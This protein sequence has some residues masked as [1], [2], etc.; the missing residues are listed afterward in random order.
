MIEIRT[1]WGDDL[2]RLCIDKN[3]YTRG[4]N[5]EYSVLLNKAA[6]AVNVTTELIVELAED[7]KAHSDTEHDLKGICFEI[8]RKCNVFFENAEP[9][10]EKKDCVEAPTTEHYFIGKHDLGTFPD[11]LFVIECE[12]D[13]YEIPFTPRT[14]HEISRAEF[15]ELAGEME[16]RRVKQPYRSQDIP[17]FVQ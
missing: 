7:I 1:L 10:N 14:Y 2:R 6:S 16:I 11:I 5:E 4:V 12:G 3:W 9:E 15:L 8:A 13:E 17:F